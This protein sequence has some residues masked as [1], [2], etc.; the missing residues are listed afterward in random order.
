MRR[1]QNDFYD[2]NTD[3]MR[4]IDTYKRLL[5]VLAAAVILAAQTGMFALVWYGPYREI[6]ASSFVRGNYVIIGLYALMVFFFCNIYGGFHF[7]KARVFEVFYSQTLSILCTNVIFYLQLCL[8]CRWKLMSNIVPMGMLTLADLAVVP[9]WSFFTRWVYQKLYPPRKM[10]L[11]Y[12]AYSPDNLIRKIQSRDDRYLIRDTVSIDEDI[13]LIRSKILEVGNV[14]LTDI[15]AQ[16]RNDLLKFCFENNIRCYYVP[17]ISDVMV[18]SADTIHLMDTTLLLLRNMG[19]TGDQK[20]LKRI[21]DVVM[22]LI[23][24]AVASPVMLL[25]ALAIKIYDGGPVLFTQER[26]TENGDVFTV[27]KFRS[28][29]VEKEAGEYV[30][31]RKNDDR[32]TPVGK[33]IRNIHFDELPQLFNILRGDMSF[34]GPRPECPVLAEEYRQTIPEF[35]YRLKVKAG[36]TGYAQVY[37]KYNTTPYDKLKLDLY[38]IENYSFWLDVK[39]ILLTVKILFQKENTEGIESWQTSAARE[40]KMDEVSN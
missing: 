37:G 34:V 26:L 30:M 18:R 32:V 16:I 22:A 12:G 14:V 35:N 24:I 27:F 36:L 11:V 33:V 6:G 40:E 3:T 9:A 25:I 38:Y 19:L 10:L 2:R 5:S 13:S 15:P 8:I 21:F 23:A 28:M 29:R 20:L 17:K 7:G 1:E 31:T 4:V 39:L